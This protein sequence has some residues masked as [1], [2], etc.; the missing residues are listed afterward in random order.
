MNIAVELHKFNNIVF[1]EKE[2]RYTINGKD[3]IS[4][5]TLLNNYKEKFDSDLI[6]GKYAK[7]HGLKKEDVLSLWSKE[8]K[9]STDKGSYL[10]K[11]AENIWNKKITDLGTTAW[12]DDGTN[13]IEVCKNHIESFYNDAK[14]NLALVSAELVVGDENVGVCG[15]IDKL[16]YNIKTGNYQ[17]WDYKTNKDIHSD[18]YA[19]KL[20]YPL[21]S[22]YDSKINLYSLQLSMYKWIIQRN[23]NI[24][25]GDCYLVWINE[26]NDSYKIIKTIDYTNIV[27]DLFLHDIL[28]DEI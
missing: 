21:D 13:D 14:K 7:K 24:F 8:N 17:I 3:A 25:I 15:M 9:K 18:K 4:V 23:T 10:H 6:A 16:F 12:F 19:K 20:K 5:T 26:N 1:S 28:K 2:H 11:F 27:S 22:I